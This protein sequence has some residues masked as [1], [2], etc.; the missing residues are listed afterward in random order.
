MI[1]P[2]QNAVAMMDLDAAYFHKDLNCLPISH[3]DLKYKT[4]ALISC[5]RELA[6]YEQHNWNMASTWR[7]DSI[8]LK[9]KEL[10]GTRK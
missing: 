4:K 6:Q 9:I 7:R 5:D 10:W 2:K 1:T 8:F 3:S